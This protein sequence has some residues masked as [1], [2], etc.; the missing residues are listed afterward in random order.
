MDLGREIEVVRTDRSKNV[1]P[2]KRLQPLRNCWSPSCRGQGRCYTTFKENKKNWCGSRAKRVIDPQPP[3]F[4]HQLDKISG[5]FLSRFPRINHGTLQQP[6]NFNTKELYHWKV[7]T[8]IYRKVRYCLRVAAVIADIPLFMS[9][10][11]PGHWHLGI[12]ATL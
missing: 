11:G 9:T 5:S 6:R 2:Q 4:W 8:C 3:L 1:D 7:I 10:A 12:L